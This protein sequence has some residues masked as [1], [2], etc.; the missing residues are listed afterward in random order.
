METDDTPV[1]EKGLSETDESLTCITESELNKQTTSIDKQQPSYGAGS[2]VEHSSSDT[3][4]YVNDKDKK[5][6]A[7]NDL[8][9]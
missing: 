3:G 8:T 5:N 4:E 2:K 6:V 9:S 1:A 7:L